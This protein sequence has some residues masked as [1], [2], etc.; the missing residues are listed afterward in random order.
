LC[1][2]HLL[3]VAGGVAEVGGLGLVIAEISKVQRRE[4]PEHRGWVKRSLAWLRRLTGQKRS[5]TVHLAGSASARGN[6]R[7]VLSVSGSAGPPPTLEQRVERLEAD[8]RSHAEQAVKD[9]GE[10]HR[11]VR[12]ANERIDKAARELRELIEQREDERREGLADSLLLQ[13]IG[14]AAFIVG[15]GLSVWGNLVPC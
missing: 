7:G 11:A 1:L 12:D 14:T 4:F 6:A 3:T 9:R 15:V 2:S 5:H 13:K 8:L 10:M